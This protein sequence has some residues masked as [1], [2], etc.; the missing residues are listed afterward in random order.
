[1]LKFL[2]TLRPT[3]RDRTDQYRELFVEND[4][5]G[6]VLLGLTADKL[7]KARAAPDNANLCRGLSRG[8]ESRCKLYPVCIVAR[9]VACMV[10]NRC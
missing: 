1:M 10:G 7:E 4:I 5:D 9:T 6:V 2:E 8:I 3:F